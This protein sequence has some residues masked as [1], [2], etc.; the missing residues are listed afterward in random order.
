MIVKHIGADGKVRRTFDGVSSMYQHNGNSTISINRTQANID[1]NVRPNVYTFEYP[2][3][4]VNLAP[5]ESIER[6]DEP[7]RA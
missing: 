6:E 2:I 3:A 5:G 1:P 4:L 7:I